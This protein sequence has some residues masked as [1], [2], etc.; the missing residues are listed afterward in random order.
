MSLVKITFSWKVLVHCLEKINFKKSFLANL[1]STHR[2]ACVLVHLPPHITFKCKWH[3]AE[4]AIHLTSATYPVL[5]YIYLICRWHTA[6]HAIQSASGPPRGT[7]QRSTARL[8][9]V[10]YSLF[11][12]SK[13]KKLTTEPLEM[14]SFIKSF[15][16]LHVTNI[17]ILAYRF[18]D[19]HL[20]FCT[21]SDQYKSHRLKIQCKGFY[22]TRCA[23]FGCW[24]QTT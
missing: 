18:S 24:L 23:K 10:T 15:P 13:W 11:S 16:S 12:Q 7:R 1:K 22:D 17:L 21:L 4:H 6:D 14:F 8:P 20:S 19:V 3:T 5:L 2:R 9:V